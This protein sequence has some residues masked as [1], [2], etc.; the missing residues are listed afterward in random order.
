MVGDARP[1]SARDDFASLL[2]LEAPLFAEEAHRRWLLTLPPFRPSPEHPLHARALELAPAAV[3]VAG[4]ALLVGEHRGRGALFW[5]APGDPAARLIPFRGEA[6][7]QVELAKRIVPRALP[8]LVD[9]S[10]LDA[11]LPGARRGEL[12][13]RILAPMAIRSTV[14]VLAR[15]RRGARTKARA[16][17]ALAV[18]LLAAASLSAQERAA[19]EIPPEND[20]RAS[21]PPPRPPEGETARQAERLFEAIQRNDPEHARDFFFP[22]EPFR[23]LKGIADPDRYWNV[24]W[25]HYERDIAALHETLP[26]L[27]EGRFSRF[28]MSRRGGWVARRQEANA[29]PY[30]ACRHSFVYYRAGEREHRFEIRTLINWGPRWYVTHLR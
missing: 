29:L 11:A 2:A 18:A 28:L 21:E 20:P 3:H 5:I 4:T 10:A 17:L 16:G 27:A 30:W 26:S 9:P 1:V 15:G 25:R 22:R 7:E 13:R 19:I 24:L 12:E 6:R 14:P 8:A 23:V